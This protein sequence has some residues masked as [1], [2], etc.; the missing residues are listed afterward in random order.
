MLQ[1]T[2]DLKNYLDS[3]NLTAEQV[4]DFE[5]YLK[6]EVESWYEEYFEN[7]Y[8]NFATNKAFYYA[9][10]QQILDICN[11][12]LEIWEKDKIK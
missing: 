4:L 8:Q 3:L 1:L 11:K 10:N 6:P 5:N 9:T 7:N 2:K 12:Y